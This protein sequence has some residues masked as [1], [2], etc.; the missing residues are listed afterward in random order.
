[1]NWKDA[2]TYCRQHH[3]DLTTVNDQTDLTELLKSLPSG[4]R[5][6]F[7]IGLYRT[8]RYAPWVWSDRSKSLF[9]QWQPSQPNNAA[10]IQYCVYT[11]TTG[12]WNDWECPDTLPFMCYTEKK[13]QI[14]RL[15]VKSS[16]NVN[17]P[18]VKNMT[19]A[20]L[21]QIL[22]EKG[23]TKD[24]KLSWMMFSE[25]NVFHKM[26]YQKSDAF[27]ASCRRTHN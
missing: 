6:D 8:D 19:L 26:W 16:K 17:D 15:E 21:G 2:Q 4:F 10:G 22:K 9:R 5:D 13:I 14:V 24:A 25:E 20:K 3:T 18:A 7:W 1:M 12:Y 23:L 27:N 11:S